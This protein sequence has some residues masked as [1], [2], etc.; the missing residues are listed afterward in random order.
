MDVDTAARLSITI[1]L[2]E[3]T[4]ESEVYLRLLILYNLLSSNGVR[5]KECRAR[6]MTRMY[7]TKS[8]TQKNMIITYS[9]VSVAP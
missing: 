2:Q 3:P 9:M 5:E 8:R 7:F 1:S 4:P 6:A